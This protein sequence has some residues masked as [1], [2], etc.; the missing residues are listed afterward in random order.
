M[1]EKPRKSLIQLFF[2]KNPEPCGQLVL[3]D[4]SISIR[5]KLVKKLKGSNET[6]WL[7]FKQNVMGQKLPVH[8][9]FDLQSM[10]LL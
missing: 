2:K 1:F 8:P 3:P 10:K 4:R 7:I 6:F 9:V 5:Q